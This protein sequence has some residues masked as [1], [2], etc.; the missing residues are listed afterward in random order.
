MWNQQILL[1]LPG[2][3]NR[4]PAWECN[5]QAAYWFH[6]TPAFMKIYYSYSCKW[7]TNSIYQIQ[8]GW[9]GY[10]NQTIAS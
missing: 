3:S 7:E 1:S 4:E 8:D 9:I 6:S 10:E 2:E 5:R